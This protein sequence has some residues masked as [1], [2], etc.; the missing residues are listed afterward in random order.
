[1]V[2]SVNRSV[3]TNQAI[4]KKAHFPK[5]LIFINQFLSPSFMSVCAPKGMQKPA[6]ISPNERFTLQFSCQSLRKAGSLTVEGV[7]RAESVQNPHR[8]VTSLSSSPSQLGRTYFCIP[9][10]NVLLDVRRNLQAQGEIDVANEQ[11]FHQSSSY[12]AGKI[13]ITGSD[14]LL[15]A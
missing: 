4:R 12:S 3:P 14:F 9:Y 13:S 6:S 15:K 1:L 11:F 8:R 5:G 10:I 7:C 2:T